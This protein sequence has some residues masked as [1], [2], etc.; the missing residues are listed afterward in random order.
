VSASCCLLTIAPV[1]GVFD[2]EA[3]AG[4]LSPMGRPAHPP[5][6]ANAILFLAS[7]ESSHWTRSGPG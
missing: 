1:R 7:D 3:T 2:D 6:I 5:E 4:A